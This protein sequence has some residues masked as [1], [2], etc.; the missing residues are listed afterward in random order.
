MNEAPDSLRSRA[1]LSMLDLLGEGPI[2][3]LVNGSQSVYFNDTPLQNP[4]GSFNFQGVQWGMVN[5]NNDQLTA[6]N[7]IDGTYVE[8][9]FNVGAQIKT[10]TP[11][12][13][14]ID[15]PMADA[16][17]IIV[18]VPSLSTTDTNSGDTSGTSVSY[19]FQM[20]VN[21]GPFI[22]TSLGTLT[23][24][25][26]TRSKYQRAHTLKLPRPATSI[27]IRMIRLTDDSKTQYLSNDTY[28]DSYY[29]IVTL[30]MVY[31]NSA[32]FG[33]SIDSSQFNSIPQR[34]YLVD[35]L[36]V[37]VPSNYNPQTRIYTGVWNGTFKLALTNNPAW[38]LYDI[39]TNKR[40]GL[41]NYMNATQVDKAALYT[42][43]RY[44][45]E[46][47][48]DG[49]GGMEPRFTLNTVI[50]SRADAYKVI[51]D[52]TSVFR[53]MAFW[54]GGMTSFT[55][56]APTDP[57]MIYSA[58]NVVDG[59]FS[60]TGSARKDR[61]SVVYVTWNDPSDN[62][63]KKVEYVEDP[64]LVAAYGVRKLD[65]L[66]FGCTSR[67]QAARVGKWILYTEKYES[68]FV[69]FKVGLDSAFVMPGN[70]I[71]IQD[72]SRAGKRMAGRLKSCTTTSATL[73]AEISITNANA[74]ISIML[75]DGSF[76]DRTVLQGPGKYTQLTWASPLTTMP[77]ANAMWLVSEATLVP[78]LA[79][80]VSVVQGTVPGQFEIAAIEHNPSKFDSIEKNLTLVD[81]PISIID[82]NFVQTPTNLSVSE[83]IY[84]AG[85]GTVAN[86]IFVSWTGD[87]NAYDVTY[88]GTS[89]SNLSNVNKVR[90]QNALSLEIPSA[91]LGAYTITVTGINPLGK[92][93]TTIST[94]YQCV[95]KQTPPSTVP[96]MYV[97]T[98]QQ[99]IK[100]DW[101]PVTDIDLKTYEVRE[102]ATP[103]QAWDSATK[104]VQTTSTTFSLATRSVGT[105]EWIVRALDTSGRYSAGDARV[106]L[107][108]KNPNTPVVAASITQDVLKL[109][110]TDA[111]SV[112]AIAGYEVRV[113]PNWAVG[114]VVGKVAGQTL[115]L[116]V[117]WS[118]AQTFWV[119]ATDVAGNTSVQGSAVAT[120]QVPAVSGLTAQVASDRYRLSWTG[121]PTSLSITEYEVRIGDSTSTWSTATYVADVSAN[122]WEAK[123]DWSGV[124]KL[125]VVAVDAAGNESAVASTT[126]N[127]SAPAT[128]TMTSAIS[129]TNLTLS[130]ATPTAGSVPL[131]GYE[132][133]TGSGSWSSASVVSQLK[134]NSLTLPITWVGDRT[135]QIVAKDLA[136]NSSAITTKVVTI[137]VPATPAPS[138]SFLADMFTLGWATP[139]S[140]LPIAEYEV[141]YGADW[142]AGA[143]T[144]VRVKASIFTISAQWAGT[145][146]W[147]V[148]G[149][150]S[151]GNMGQPGALDVTINAPSAPVM[152][153]KVVDNN[154]LLYWSESTGTLPVATYELRRGDTFDSA[155]SIGK[156]SGGFTTV[157]ETA[158]GLYTY[159][160]AGIDTAG[161]YGTPSSLAVTVDQPPDYILKSSDDLNFA[162]GT[163]YHMALD[164][165]GGYIMPVNTTETFQEHF[166]THGWQSPNDQTGAGF[167]VFIE[168]AQSP[169]YY[170]Q[171]LDYGAVLPATKI[172][173]TPNSLVVAGTPVVT[174]TISTRANATDAWTDY[175]VSSVYASEFRYVKVRLSVS[176]SGTD[177][178]KLYGINVKLDSKQRNDAGMGVASLTDAVS[179]TTAIIAGVTTTNANPLNDHGVKVPNGDGTLVRFNTPFIDVAAI[180]L[181][182][183]AG[184]TAVSAIYDFVDVPYA[185]GFKVILLDKNGNRVSGS[186]SWSAKGQ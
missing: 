59:V 177:L 39:L 23:I 84:L 144:A 94:V 153:K 99:G 182:V 50:A 33:F 3:G 80:V 54:G 21:G 164:T 147:W 135:F 62:Y 176:G 8:A 102:C 48:P 47:V 156:K 136:G 78:M 1:V 15:N 181:S 110:W 108:V 11:H 109:D 86:K 91:Q 131:D 77:V 149:I 127:I 29:E 69:T 115:S 118:G 63:K 114:S 103:G 142:T 45:D 162:T 17:R 30:N 85:P 90:V 157:F 49:L 31:P 145:R 121:V 13:F 123:I 26:K 139:A 184:S 116:P 96:G 22:D 14:T 36:Y 82:A 140:T 185:A 75:E 87:S 35:G 68:D 10:T 20:S 57:T 79:R 119:Q 173:V 130:W 150:D 46:M 104:V 165:D 117:T 71:K 52:I 76:V 178:Y 158:A 124:K 159:W 163:Q 141:R 126:L 160:L 133:R 41:G 169:G 65:T 151:N 93:S 97:S 72:A 74:T 34:A 106:S 155:T 100:L 107:V 32:I 27:S 113:G 128:P 92:R 18:N 112:F 16:V 19:K 129:G 137:Q 134:G 25:G 43:G 138:G 73:D 166:T 67:G 179:G 122:T 143:S 28:L 172:T 175:N 146:R 183:A 170:E 186:F 56:D 12:T 58:S 174:I 42:I 125:Y 83:S 44:C 60:Y 9:P 161:N 7:L 152:T 148:A 5:G 81:R 98:S 38:V 95:G 180:D 89:P 70:I 167:P 171:V 24:S 154:V 132:V 101:S 53:G 61:H 64:D 168:P 40:Y 51:S 105:Y 4:D 6:L 2:G 120:I 66:A 88:Q 111:T 55:Q 37:Q